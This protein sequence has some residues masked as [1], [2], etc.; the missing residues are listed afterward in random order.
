MPQTSLNDRYKFGVDVVSY[1]IA[2]KFFWYQ[3]TRLEVMHVRG[4]RRLQIRPQAPLGGVKTQCNQTNT[5]PNS[6]LTQKIH[7]SRK[8]HTPSRGYNII[9]TKLPQRDQSIFPTLPLVGPFSATKYTYTNTAPTGPNKTKNPT[10]EWNTRVHMVLC[11][12]M[13]E[14]LHNFETTRKIRKIPPPFR[15]LARCVPHPNTIP[16]VQNRKKQYKI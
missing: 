4:G 3:I 14:I 10:T 2:S 5:S 7:V 1:H 13:T 8:T 12:E 9:S 6:K 16:N 11:K 15:W